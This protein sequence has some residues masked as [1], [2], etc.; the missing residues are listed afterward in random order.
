MDKMGFKRVMSIVVVF[1]LSLGSF[2]SMSDGQ[3]EDGT[4]VVYPYPAKV[5]LTLERED[6]SPAS[7]F[8]VK[9]QNYYSSPPQVREFLTD[10][11]GE[12]SFQIDAPDWGP[13]RIWAHDPM[14]EY[15]WTTDLLAEP[16]GNYTLNGTAAPVLPWNNTL[17]GIV[18]N[19]ESG[20]PMS[21]VQILMEGFD[22][23]GRDLSDDT[24]SGPDGSYELKLPRS[25]ESFELRATMTGYEDHSSEVYVVPG[26]TEYHVDIWMREV[27]APG[28]MIQVKAFNSTTAEEMPLQ[29]VGYY[30]LDSDADHTHVNGYSYTPNSTTGY[31]EM[32]AGPGEYRLRA[33][34]KADPKLNVSFEMY[35]Y[36]AVNGSGLVHHMDLPVPSEWRE[37][38]V[39]IEEESG[40]MYYAYSEYDLDYSGMR[41]MG[42]TYTDPSGHA[43]IYIPS[44]TAVNLRIWDYSYTSVDIPIEAG[45]ATSIVH[46]NATLEYVGIFT[47]PSGQVSLLVKDEITG[48]PV[49]ETRV[50]AS[51]YVRPGEYWISM[52]GKTSADGYLNRTVDAGFYPVVRLES[53]LGTGT[54]ENITIVE[55]GTTDLVGTISRRSFPPEFVMVE[56]KM[57]TR[58]GDPVP[59]QPV[60]LSGMGS[61]SMDYEP[62][63]GSEGMVKL[64]VLPGDYRISM[65][66]EY[67][68]TRNVR[69][70]WTVRETEVT[71]TGDIILPDLVL[72]P[73]GPLLSLEGFVRDATTYDIIPQQSVMVSSYHDLAPEPSR[74]MP[75]IM[76]YWD[77]LYEDEEERLYYFWQSYS[78]SNNEGFYR[79]WGGEKVHLYADRDGYYFY[80]LDLD[81]T[82]RGDISHDILLEPIPEY[83]TYVNGTLMDQDGEPL[84]GI[85]ALLDVPHRHH[86][87]GEMMVDT[88]GTFSIECYPGE[89]RAL[90]G[91]ESLWD[92]IDIEVPPEG[93]EGL[94]LVLAPSTFLNGTVKDWKDEP[95]PDINVTL[96]SIG[97]GGPVLDQWMITGQDGN[98][99][100]QVGKGTYRM[101][102][103]ETEDYY[104]HVMDNIETLGWVPIQ[105]DIVLMNRTSGTL[106]GT[107]TGAGGPFE[108]GI[109]GCSVRLH[110][111]VIETTANTTTDSAGMYSFA[112]MPYAVNWTVEVIPPELYAGISG[113]R[114]G[115]LPEVI[116]NLTMSM[117]RKELNVELQFIE[118]GEY[119][120]VNVTGWGPVG[121]D[122]AL[123]GIIWVEFSEPMD[124]ASVEAALQI[125]PD[126]IVTSIEW[127]GEGTRILLHHDDLAPETNYTIAVPGHVVSLAGM[128][129]WDPEGFQWTFRTG[130]ELLEWFLDSVEI[131]VGPDRT[132]EVE[133]TGGQGQSVYFVIVDVGSFGFTEG[134]DGT[135]TVTVN[136]SHL[137]WS[138]MYEYYFSDIEDG[139]DRWPGY[140]GTFTTPDEPVPTD[141]DDDVDDDTNDDT[142]DDDV[143]DDDD[144]DDVATIAG[145]GAL[146][147]G[148]VLLVV[149]AIV[150]VVFVVT[151]RKS[152][153]WEEE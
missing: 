146:I 15:W 124:K 72:H 111:P 115:Y 54:M 109:P 103:E 37:V 22:D 44:W 105:I 73:T 16:N 63:S 86:L 32:N 120:M 3:Q 74:Q 19:A 144:D 87:V 83:T 131:Y 5:R 4:R 35:N 65:D 128:P 112:G 136:R 95:V 122:V 10:T 116:V 50:T 11:S 147:C 130:T 121:D 82:T 149:I 139:E 45:P 49:P 12:V 70:S 102:I 69:S 23:L 101:V 41:I 133:V 20:D 58:S 39:F 135:Y 137:L 29:S 84:S 138:T 113:M 66:G 17:S 64:W 2:V 80:D 9:L 114:S 152:E 48:L 56:F 153:G 25:H 26:N 94:E 93:V 30:G 90:F 142:D 143:S 108:G 40:P 31:F 141:D 43:V 28:S 59:N 27:Y 98:F 92:Y 13:C 6:S 57:I 14:V 96:F 36:V 127:N 71:I 79:A 134:A 52:Y 150:I 85:V 62:I 7:G 81:T 125:L 140:R 151:R 123:N 18:R 68:S 75:Y 100:F 34:T 104:D 38:R 67:H 76:G 51:A 91:N 33:T 21:G 119:P 148:M 145:R 97:T 107:V 8:T 106:F 99:T 24:L 110:H 55:S 61:H 60:T 42:D 78:G 77:Q 46:A 1:L 118:V 129:L 126:I 88:S 47:P 89:L 53:T 132:V 117:F